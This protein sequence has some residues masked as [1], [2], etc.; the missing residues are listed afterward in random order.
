MTEIGGDTASFDPRT[1]ALVSTAR[2]QLK[3]DASQ[4]N[5]NCQDCNPP[6]NG[7]YLGADNQ[8]I[9]IMATDADHFVWALDDA[10][11]LYRARVSNIDSPDPAGVKVTLV[12]PPVDEEHFPLV[13]RVVEI[14]PFAALLDDS[15]NPSATADPSFNKAAAEIGAFTR[16]V[17]SYDPQTQSFRVDQFL[18][19]PEAAEFVHEWD[20]QHPDG[21]RLNVVPSTGDPTDRFVYVRFWHQST[22]HAGVDVQLAMPAEGFGLVLEGTAVQAFFTGRGRPGDFWIAAVRPETPNPIIPI[23]LQN[24]NGMPPDGPR[25]FYA[26]LAL[27]AIADDSTHVSAVMDCRPR[28]RPTGDD[29]CSTV[30]VGDCF[31][32]AGDFTTI[33]AAIAAL[34][35]DGGVVTIRP[36]LYRE[37]VVIDRPGVILEG[38]GE[39]TVLL[40][41]DNGD[42][43]TINAVI[44]LRGDCRGSRVR[45]MRI[46]ASEESAIIAEDGV[47]VGFSAL[48]L[49]GRATEVGSSSSSSSTT[50][51]TTDAPLVVLTGCENVSFQAIQIDSQRRPGMLFDGC[52]GLRAESMSLQGTFDTYAAPAGPMITISDGSDFK[53]R[54]VA[55][56][57]F[58]QLGLAVRGDS[59]PRDI[60]LDR[61]TIGSSFS[62]VEPVVP[63]LSGVDIENG[64]A[65]RLTRSR[66]VM[67][68]L[69]PDAP[70]DSP[71]FSPF[72][73]VVVLGNGVWIEDS[74]IEAG[75]GSWGGIQLRG[76]SNGIVV[77]GNRIRGGIGHGITLGSVIWQNVDDFTTRTNLGAGKT[78][79]TD[80]TNDGG[81]GA[82]GDFSTFNDETST[83][84]ARDEGSLQDVAILNNRIEAMSTNGIS[85]LTVLGLPVIFSAADDRELPQV[86]RLR[87]DGNLIIGN[88]VRQ[89]RQGVGFRQNLV[90]EADPRSPVAA[91]IQSLPLGGIVL[92]TVT[93][94]A[95][96]RNNLIA[97]NGNDSPVAAMNGIFILNG[98]GISI[99]GNRIQ[100]NGGLASSEFLPDRGVR[101]GIAI[102]LA[103][104]GA[105]SS[106]DQIEETL[107]AGGNE[108]PSD[109]SSVR[110]IDN[111]V[112]QPEGRALHVIAAG[113]A[114]I[115]GNFLSSAGFHG[116]ENPEDIFAIGDVVLVENIGGPWERFDIEDVPH[117]PAPFFI[118]YI[119]P[120]FFA[121]Y[122]LN[123]VAASPRFF[124]GVG[125]QV[126]FQNNQVIY[127]W[128]IQ[129]VGS[130]PLGIFPVAL[131]TL[132]HLSITGNHLALHINN[133]PSEFTPPEEL[134]LPPVRF[135]PM[136]AHLF[137]A[138]GTVQIAGN[139]VASSVI[140]VLL[141][142]WAMGEMATMVVSNQTTLDNFSRTNNLGFLT[143]TDPLEDGT[144][145][146]SNQ[147]MFSDGVAQQHPDFF[148]DTMQLYFRLLFRPSTTVPLPPA[149]T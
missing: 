100:G 88:V 12:T 119:G 135:T 148:A 147:V 8:T 90:T 95:D 68:D 20:G 139:R 49:V 16:V 98:E 70:P 56:Q 87:I 122:L 25:H 85:A 128:T 143:N 123:T 130:G 63:A 33:N 101:A 84:Q 9:R 73:A 89:Q 59:P 138:G 7:P 133:I 136:L 43:V 141:S 118:E 24:P 91:A 117:S 57:T 121:P 47:D 29:E 113:P 146:I 11:P 46:E 108:L 30:T 34:P 69:P 5:A 110:I 48:H 111:V 109:G 74:E 10:A 32:S 124:V 22:S 105:P 18:G 106:F 3:F 38:C 144:F 66:I 39:N 102:M 99:S 45:S 131:M 6:Q 76:D 81:F 40:S 78:L 83:F 137:A 50:T 104:T 75:P 51:A 125:G 44:R 41:P 149:P 112:T 103:G 55:I 116:S 65:V 134:P 126:L 114:T 97:N 13:G 15:D 52:V 77:R 79:V 86:Q 93:D 62:K 28:V 21:D 120:Q 1:G 107:L 26:P 37:R 60:E 31:G 145:A 71:L 54:D 96:I 64:F 42:R 2:L 92:A 82:G 142:I 27:V 19:I 67:G 23:D 129:R 132:D 94:V 14:L 17:Q 61:L 35:S 115:S 127:D 140:D 72:A 58:G 80:Q 53:L 36:G 4:A